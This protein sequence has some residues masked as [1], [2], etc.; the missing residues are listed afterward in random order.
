M[1]II[2]EH[3]CMQTCIPFWMLT[4]FGPWWDLRLCTSIRNAKV[5]P[6][7]KLY[8]CSCICCMLIIC[9]LRTLTH[10]DL[11]FSRN[12][13]G[14]HYDVIA[15]QL[16]IPMNKL[17]SLSPAPSLMCKLS[18]RNLLTSPSLLFD[19]EELQMLVDN[20]LVYTTIN[21]D[22]YK[23]TVNAWYLYMFC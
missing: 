3:V 22:Y 19:R 4:T 1:Q 12:T 13:E 23:S 15:R 6:V 16:N 7:V 14:A 11:Q 17:K 5:Y 9:C 8:C 10:R 21:D 18:E 2:L 20:G